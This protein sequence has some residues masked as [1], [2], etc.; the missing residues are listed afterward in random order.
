MGNR[1]GSPVRR[2]VRSCF[3]R[4]GSGSEGGFSLIEVIIAVVILSLTFVTLLHTESQGIDMA[5]RARFMTT[6]TLLAQEKISEVTS[7]ARNASVGETKGDFGEDFPGYTYI[8][9]VETTPLSGYL[10]YTI[11]VDWGGDRSKLET[12]IISFIAGR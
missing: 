10:K 5:M 7:G 6:S 2:P 1:S 9:K 12:K 3:S 4:T 8:E 11:T